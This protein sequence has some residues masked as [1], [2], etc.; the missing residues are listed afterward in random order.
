M[1][2][3]RVYA[4]LHCPSPFAVTMLPVDLPVEPVPQPVE[5]TLS[6]EQLRLP[7][8]EKVG[9]VG[10]TYQREL[11]PGWYGG[12]GFYGAVTGQR[13]GSSPGALPE[14]GATGRGLG[15]PKPVCSSAAGAAARPGSAAG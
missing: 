9:V 11:A 6:A 5:I 14:P 10:A 15:R 12:W 13:G 8:S 3:R 1:P 2:R 7:A 4:C